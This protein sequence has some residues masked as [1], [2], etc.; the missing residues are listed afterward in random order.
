MEALYVYKMLSENK[1]EEL[2]AKA[3][4]EAMGKKAKTQGQGNLYKAR[5]KLSK[6]CFKLY[7]TA[8]PN[9]AGAFLYDGKQCVCNMYYLGLYDEVYDGL[10]EVKSPN[11][12]NVNALLPAN[13][14]GKQCVYVNL[15]ELKKKDKIFRLEKGLNSKIRTLVKI[16]N[17]YVDVAYLTDLC[18]TFSNPLIYAD[19]N[20]YDSYIYIVAK[21]GRGCI[22]PCRHKVVEE[23]IENQYIVATYE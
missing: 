22:C 19:L 15:D 10:V 12:I 18:D 4:A 3:K 1:I 20:N 6:E 11:T 5:L 2:M 7:K 14:L 17:S 13:D 16:L 23:D 9:I 21:N 8:R